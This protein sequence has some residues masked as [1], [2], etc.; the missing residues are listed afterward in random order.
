M[1]KLGP[2]EVTKVQI[3]DQRGDNMLPYSQKI[4]K[5]LPDASGSLN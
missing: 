1:T 3:V 4:T 2:T 5:H